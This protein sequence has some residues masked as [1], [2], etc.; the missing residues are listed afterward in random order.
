M[1]QVLIVF[2][3]KCGQDSRLSENEV[4]MLLRRVSGQD[5]A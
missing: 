5:P 1:R 3:A 4:E 2:F